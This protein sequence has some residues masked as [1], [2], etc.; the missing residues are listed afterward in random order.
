MISLITYLVFGDPSK[1]TSNRSSYLIGKP[2]MPIV[3]GYA[4]CL[5]SNS[6]EVMHCWYSRDV[7]SIYLL[8]ATLLAGQL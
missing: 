5:P 1:T 8:L 2:K 3:W 7:Y 4:R 6:R